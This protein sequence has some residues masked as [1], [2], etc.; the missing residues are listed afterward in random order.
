[1]L[2]TPWLE[3]RCWNKCYKTFKKKLNSSVGSQRNLQI[4][5]RC[6]GFLDRNSPACDFLDCWW[7]FDHFPFFQLGGI[8][9]GTTE[10]GSSN[11]GARLPLLLNHGQC[12]SSFWDSSGPYIK[13]LT[14]HTQVQKRKQRIG[15]N[16]LTCPFGVTHCSF[17]FQQHIIGLQRSWILTLYTVLGDR[18]IVTFSYI[19]DNY[20]APHTAYF[21]YP[22]LSHVLRAQFGNQGSSPK[23]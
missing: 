22:Q 17:S 23:L 18:Q 13:A 6:A 19:Q 20:G 10:R 15:A 2:L 3:A 5:G 8:K 12:K 4:V 7:Y 9:G 11:L 1:M 21:D 14:T 16:L